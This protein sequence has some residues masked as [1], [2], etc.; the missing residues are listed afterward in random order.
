MRYAEVIKI[1]ED[2]TTLLYAIEFKFL[3]F[4]TSENSGV[5]VASHQSSNLINIPIPGEIV[6]IHDS[7]NAN[8]NTNSYSISYYYTKIISIRNSISNNSISGL[9]TKAKVK[10]DKKFD[11]LT[12]K[13]E[14][15]EGDL[16]L[17]SRFG[18]YLLQSTTNDTSPWSSGKYGDPIVVLG[19]SKDT[20]FNINKVESAIYITST[21]DVNLKLG[22][23][24]YN[25]NTVTF[26]TAPAGKQIII[27]S[28]RLILNTN[29]KE[30]LISSKTNI[31][32]SA[33]KSISIES[34]DIIALDATSIN[35]GQVATSP[36]VKGDEL[37]SILL[38]AF[39]R[40]NGALTAPSLLTDILPRLQTILSTK[41]KIE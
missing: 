25:L 1:R 3:N 24:R 21:Q 9:T 30:I 34:G 28:D 20:T 23:D 17:Q 26:K 38:D 33:K 15:S 41:V 8:S 13:K 27:T 39:N 18:S 12:T 14:L 5:F 36:A 7:I 29:N 10:L 16:L 40:I 19:V 11:I 2:I 31:A 37:F 32:L 6:E 4:K 35:L 22:S